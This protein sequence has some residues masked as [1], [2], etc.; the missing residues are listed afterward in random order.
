[1]TGPG[2]PVLRDDYGAEVRYA[3]QLKTELPVVAFEH[4]T[5]RGLEL[6]PA[7]ADS[8]VD[9]RIPPF[10]RGELPHFAGISPFPK[11]PPRGAEVHRA[12]CRGPV[13]RDRGHRVLAA[14]RLRRYHLVDGRQGHLRHRGQPR[15]LRSPP[16]VRGELNRPCDCPSPC[17]TGGRP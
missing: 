15:P 10:S 9:R 17:P 16:P 2:D 4:E 7:G 13:D 5:V 11:A 8:I 14:V 3:V 6:R 1:M 12:C